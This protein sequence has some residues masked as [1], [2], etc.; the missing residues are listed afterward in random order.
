MNRKVMDIQKVEKTIFHYVN[1]CNIH[2]MTTNFLANYNAIFLT[3]P[4]IGQLECHK[5]KTRGE[6]PVNKELPDILKLKGTIVRAR[7]HALV[8][9]ELLKKWQKV[10][11]T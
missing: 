8:K 6:T 2:R 11:I 4:V 7:C 3:F 10:M 5:T 1:Y 9:H